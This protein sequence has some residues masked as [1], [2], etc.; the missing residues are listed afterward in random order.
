MIERRS[1]S[2]LFR[3]V[4]MK[5]FVAGVSHRTAPV[6]IREQLAVRRDELADLAHYLKW[7]A[8]LDEIV[9]L[10][11]C[12]RVEIY[13]TT[14]QSIDR[15]KSTLQL[16]SSEPVDLDPH[17]YVHQDAEA[18]RHLFRV[19]AGLESMTLGET[20]ITGQIKSAYE[21]VR[22]AG[23]T[24]P[25]FNRLFQKAFQATKEIRTRTAIG[26]GTVSIKSAAVELIEKAFS[27]ELA[28]KSVMVIGAGEMAERCVQLLVK[29]G[30][31]SIFV[32]SRS[33]D[34]AIDLTNRC[35]GDA[36]C[37]GYC[38]F[39]M[40]DVDVVVVATSSGQT[41]LALDD[42]EN[43]MKSRRNRPVLLID[44]SVPRNIDPAASQLEN[45]TLYNIDDLEALARQGAQARERELTTCHQIIETHVAALIKKLESKSERMTRTD[46]FRRSLDA[47]RGIAYP[48]PATSGLVAQPS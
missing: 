17:L 30:V 45:V 29:K 37:F 3:G 18:A 1:A 36:V 19:T 22:E 48:S 34:R 44:L 27:D 4:D 46:L 9:L 33:F 20:E 39:E 32:S 42:I 10:S 15:I 14:R 2:R 35:G 5:L 47:T 11:T 25:V 21:T 38:L 28:D 12:N 13:G 23:L 43:L 31:G 6:E 7:F 40:R 41:L 8:H 26:R 24:G 16:L